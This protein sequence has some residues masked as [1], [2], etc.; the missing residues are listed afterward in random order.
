MKVWFMYNCDAFALVGNSNTSRSAMEEKARQVFAEDVFGGLYAHDERGRTFARCL[1]KRQP[2]GRYGVSDE[3]LA[4][5]FDSV[6]EHINW[7]ARG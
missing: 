7:I 2:D 4:E 6:D 1:G 5:F 3:A